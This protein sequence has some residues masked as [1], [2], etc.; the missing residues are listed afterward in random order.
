MNE[1]LFV[2]QL[3]ESFITPVKTKTSKDK[4]YPIEATLIGAIYHSNGKPYQQGLLI[5][6][7]EKVQVP[8]FNVDLSETL[9]EHYDGMA[10]YGGIIFNHY[11]HFLLESLSRY[12]YLKN[13][14]GDIFFHYPYISS[15]GVHNFN[16]RLLSWQKEVLSSLFVDISRL[17]II[18][19]TVQFS[20]LIVPSPGFVLREWCEKQQTDALKIFGEKIKTSTLSLS[21]IQSYDKLWLS[22][23]SLT[24]GLI[25]GE[26]EFEKALEKENFLIVKPEKLSVT[27]QIK[28]YHQAKLICGFIGSAFHTLILADDIKAKVFHF[29]RINGNIN[30][31]YKFIVEAK[32]INAE[33]FEEFFISSHGILKGVIGNT[34]TDLSG[35]WNLLYM[36]GY[37]KNKHYQ[38]NDLEIKLAELDR[39]VVERFPY[40]KKLKQSKAI[41]QT[42]KTRYNN[43]PSIK[44]QKGMKLERSSVIN[45]IA[46]T[47][48]AKMYLEIGVNRGVTFNSVNILTKVAVDPKFLFTDK[49]SR[50]LDTGEKFYFH[51]ITSDDFFQDYAQTYSSFDLVYLDGLHTFE[52]TLKDLLNTMNHTHDKSIIVIDDTLPNDVFSS[53]P[54]AQECIR[55]RRSVFGIRKND[56]AWMGD[57][58][59]L[60]AFI[61]DF[62]PFL[63]YAT[64]KDNHGQTIVWQER[65][66]NV[67]PIFK[68]MN[69]IAQLSYTDFLIFKDKIFNF[70]TLDQVIEKIKF[71]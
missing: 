32:G 60:V 65:R 23:S 45:Q 3:D 12:W 37:V 6:G 62:M 69:D 8:E 41:V 55:L 63:S 56:N 17:H 7:K 25:A 42:K 46:N 22:R 49:K 43:Q 70:S 28:L 51:E 21:N 54:S 1:K 67:I 58:Y 35:I 44:M 4:M 20:K 38:D 15:P 27:E 50:E 30:N 13:F 29:K 52:Q 33:F 48:D 18:T 19:Q 64:L 40:H 36:R 61:H 57:V 16:E 59:K 10:A 34:F 14:S 53:L 2:D 71:N 9:L 11:G 24:Y 39:Q 47:I 66:N 68:N 5:R 31:N 26:K